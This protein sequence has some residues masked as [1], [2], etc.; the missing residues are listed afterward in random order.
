MPVLIP[1]PSRVEAAG[2]KPKV[3]EEYVGQVNTST[4]AVSIARMQSPPGWIEPAQTPEFAEYTVVLRG[5]LRV[6]TKSGTVDV[7]AGQAVI[8]QKGEQV[9]YSTPGPEGAEYIAVCVPAFSPATVHR[10][11]ETPDGANR[12]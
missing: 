3:I 5:M 11:G 8:V 7:Q 2:N 1:S 12:R 6:E 9:Q 10:E 4:D